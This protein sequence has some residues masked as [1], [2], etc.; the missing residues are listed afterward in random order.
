[1]KVTLLWVWATNPVP[2]PTCSCEICKQARIDKKK[3][4]TRPSLYLENWILID[5]PQDIRDQLNREDAWIITDVFY[6]HWHP[7]HTYW[8]FIFEDLFYAKKEFKKIKIHLPTNM[9]DDFKKHVPD[10]FYLEK[11]WFIEIHTIEDRKWITINT[12]KVTPLDMYRTDRVRYNYLLNSWNK[13]II[14]APCSCFGMDIDEHYLNIDY[15]FMEY[16]WIWDSKKLRWEYNLWINNFTHRS[17]LDHISF[18]EN[19]EIINR[20]KPKNSFLIHWDFHNTYDQLETLSQKYSVTFP[21][22]G[23]C[24]EI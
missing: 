15:F 24:L 14:Y 3:Y 18:D 4:S 10:L 11:Q 8:L 19:I 6:T 13:R 12:V 1:M 7:D 16:W 9:V 2:I 21:L 5:T 20:I 17:C 22:D 23:L